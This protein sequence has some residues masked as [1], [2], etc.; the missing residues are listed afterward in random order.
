LNTKENINTTLKLSRKDKA[1]LKLKELTK[2]ML[3]KD[4]EL[5]EDIGFD[6]QTIGDYIDVSRNNISKELNKLLR[7]NAVIKI[8]GKPVLYLDK[9]SIEEKFNYKINENVFNNFDTF[10]NS[11][12]MKTSNNLNVINNKKEVK[13]I[14]KNKK[15]NVNIFD[16]IIGF[17][18]SL[19]NQI[20][21]GK[22]AM[23]YPPNG[24]HVLITGPTGV[25]KTTLAEALYL[26][27]IE[28]KKLL[29]DAPF[30]VFN[31]ADYSDNPQL[32]V[33]Q[34][35]GHTKGAFTGANDEKKGLIEKANN[36]ILFLDEV[37]R[38]S[39]EGQE[40][41]FL[42][43]DK[44]I[45]RR[46]G[47]S[48]NTRKANVLLITATTENPNS[49]M[50]ATFLRRI[51]VVIN[52]PSLDERTL[53]ERM[54]LIYKF[55]MQ[56]SNS[57][58]KAIKVPKEVIKALTL[59]ECKGN[60]GQLKS[61]IQLI[62]ARA[63]LYFL[64][65]EKEYLEVRLSKLPDRVSEGFLKMGKERNELTKYF[66]LNTNE[67]IIFD[68]INNDPYNGLQDKIHLNKYNVNE[69]FYDFI[70]DTW[71]SLSKEKLSDKQRKE[72]IE[73]MIELY[74]QK[75]FHR[76]KTEDAKINY[77]ALRKIVN[78][79]VL[80]VVKDVV[81]EQRQVFD[82]LINEKIICGLSLHINTLL[83]R[84]KTNKIIK[85]PNQDTIFSE[86]PQEYMV[87]KDL[88][89]RLEKSLNINIPEAE[90]AFFTMLL[91]AGNVDTNKIGVL[92]I[93]HGD[94]AA[95]TMANVANSLVGVDHVHAIDMALDEKIETALE[96]AIVKAK[97]IDMGKGVFIMI[98]MGSTSRFGEII[99]ERTGIQTR[100]IGMV[101]TLMVIEATR[102]SLIP[103]MNLDKLYEDII[104]ISPFT[105]KPQSEEIDE[106][107]I[108]KYDY[109]Y[110]SN[111]ETDHFRKLIVDSIS[112]MAIFINAE[113]ACDVLFIVLENIMKMFG[114]TV[115]NIIITK[116]LFHG[117][118]MIER[119]I[120]KEPLPYKKIDEV[121]KTRNDIFT[122]IKNKFLIV[123]ETFAIT[124]P[125]T[126]IAYILEIIDTHINTHIDTHIDTHIKANTDTNIDTLS[127]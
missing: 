110:L 125:D 22:A 42:L 113:K 2:K 3:E 58:G 11:L 14:S 26:Y 20:E 75:I 101:S 108:P 30:V 114:E 18:D 66:N 105:V 80:D 33:S 12:N 123:E 55:F 59:Y 36:G 122:E 46:L 9:E 43:M 41:L 82:K 103:D 96:K 69:D 71:E 104:N 94:A 37:H 73:N 32:L 57:V 65:S 107:E 34:L 27:A 90:L 19:K 72:K 97:Q 74:S 62:S 119:A 106:S 64:T 127:M 117:T 109:D 84:I 83:E 77:E 121:K 56:E 49:A 15:T 8:T 111:C 87:A 39:P 118:F 16:R 81:H 50:L 115:N 54:N 6:A 47:E 44:K 112:K 93:T 51:P 60:I 10:K 23:L 35:F 28:E 40:M 67:D 31:C 76:M 88:K 45:F 53:K 124:I 29:K 85:Y 100:T 79:R 5:I 25:G 92:V 95:R 98:D 13:L 17:D 68:G 21:L 91:Y 78:P 99:T 116:F 7:E 48:E 86:H 70:T 38:L 102:K 61:D 89:E 126:E 120:K 52:L 24:L 1:Y 4:L 63:Y